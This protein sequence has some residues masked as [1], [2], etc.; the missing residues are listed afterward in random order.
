MK[1]IKSMCKAALLLAAFSLFASPLQAAPYDGYSYYYWG[2]TASTP[3][4]YLPEKVIDGAEQGVGKLN[5]PTDMFVGADGQVYVLDAGNGR[6]VVFDKDW[7]A[8][9]QIRE[10]KNGAKQERFANPQGIFVTDHG[11]IYVADTDNSRVV[12]LEG[13]GTFVREIG[14]PKA[15]VIRAGFEYFP[16]K[17]AVDRAGR[18]YVIGRG[19][20]D[21]IMEMDSD[22]NFT[23]FM[24]TNKVSFNFVDYIWKQLSTKE[25]RSKL[26]QFI[27]LEF[28]NLDLDQEGFLYT[29]TAEISSEEPI[30]RLNPTGV[31][32]LRREGYIPPMGD[33]YSSNPDASS[34]LIDIKVGD[35]GIY[36]ALDSRKGG[37]LRIMKTAI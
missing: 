1:L 11:R 8:V 4:A 33:S 22:G 20:F 27:P 2:T 25:Q 29:T 26:A 14:A 35:N 37:S 19:V 32:V 34:L 5:S 24:G 16:R 21:G 17:V 12:E 10:F 18:I 3:N 6:I 30:K 7:K 23:G 28:N 13:D 15:D 31:D 36:S 9:R